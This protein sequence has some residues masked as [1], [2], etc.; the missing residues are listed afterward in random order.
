MGDKYANDA[1]KKEDS[2][3]LKFSSWLKRAAEKKQ[4]ELGAFLEE[5]K[6][7]EKSFF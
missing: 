4:T 5:N 3:F 6:C 1:G 2:E 7:L